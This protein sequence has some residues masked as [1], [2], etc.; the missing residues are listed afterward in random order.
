MPQELKPGVLYVAGEFG[1]AAHICPCGCGT[2]IRTPIGPTD[3]T[4]EVTSAG[5]TLDP[6]VGNWQLP[7]R[8]HYWIR[9]GEFLWA[10]QWSPE[11]IAAGRTEERRRA[12]EYFSG[13]DLKRRGHWRRT[14]DWFS[15]FLR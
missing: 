1:A 2:K 11:E 5:P 14:W 6:S 13:R 4:L 10:E 9:N 7:C 12:A 8:S 15:R 3:W